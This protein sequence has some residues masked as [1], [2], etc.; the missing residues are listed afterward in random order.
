MFSRFGSPEQL[1]S[2][3]GPQF[4]SQ[5]LATFLQVNGVQHIRSAP[6]HPSTNGLA[7][8]FVHT[9]KHALKASQGQGTLHQRLNSFLLA[10]RNTPHAT[11]K[12]SPALLLLKRPLRTNFDLLRPPKEKEVV[13]RQQEIQVKRRQQRAKDRTFNPEEHVL[14]RNY[15]HGP[16]WVP[17]TVIAQTGPVSYTVKTADNLI[18]RRHTDQLLLGKETPAEPRAAGPELFLDDTLSKQPLP[19]GS[20]SQ[21]ATVSAPPTQVYEETVT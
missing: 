21:E 1:V 5:E 9:M 17:A 13:R 16:K 4:V 2:D 18:W 11:T 14:A 10:C 15:L 6:Y 3:N 7:E 20:P 8:R 12:A 19:R